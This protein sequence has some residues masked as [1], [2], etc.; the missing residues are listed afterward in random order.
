MKRL[1]HELLIEIAERECDYRPY[2]L[3]NES[4]EDYRNALGPAAPA[5]PFAVD[6]VPDFGAFSNFV[7]T[8]TEARLT[9][10]DRSELEVEYRKGFWDDAWDGFFY[11][12]AVR[13]SHFLAYDA[14]L[15]EVP[16]FK[17]DLHFFHGVRT[18]RKGPYLFLKKGPMEAH[19]SGNAITLPIG[20]LSADSGDPNLDDVSAM[21]GS[22]LVDDLRTWLLIKPLREAIPVSPRKVD[23]FDVFLSHSSK[24]SLLAKELADALNAAGKRV[25][26]SP[27]SL[28]Q[29]G[30]TEYMKV[31]DNALEGSRHFILFG[32]KMENILSSWVEAEWRLFINEKRSGRK[33]GNF[34]TIIGS[35]LSLARLPLSLR[36]YEVIA[37][38]GNYVERVLRYIS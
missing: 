21:F 17:L 32:A 2:R 34:L 19:H 11:Y 3:E 7:A 4:K 13:I 31:I 29:Q 38:E 22:N 9:N 16:E 36:Y 27:N 25:F 12:P 8:L 6:L 28:P 23:R 10:M 20:S 33:S 30:S 1:L 26:F 35:D 14:Q 18:F 24:D 5:G 15:A 37:A